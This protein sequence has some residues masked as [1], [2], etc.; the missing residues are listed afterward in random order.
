M[1]ETI[2]QWLDRE[3]ETEGQF[4]S[5]QVMGDL[6]YLHDKYRCPIIT[7]SLFCSPI[8]Q[9]PIYL[10]LANP[11]TIPYEELSNSELQG[12]LDSGSTARLNDR[13]NV[14]YVEFSNSVLACLQSSNYLFCTNKDVIIVPKNPESQLEEALLVTHTDKEQ[15]LK[16]VNSSKTLPPMYADWYLAVLQYNSRLGKRIPYQCKAEAVRLYNSI[17]G[18]D[19]L[20]CGLGVDEIFN[21]PLVP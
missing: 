12:F 13:D 21:T 11:F 19:R 3:T 2:S 16:V 14:F 10:L 17:D 5:P 20:S 1:I 6:R 4:I 8:N 9:K 15:E 7:P 18:M